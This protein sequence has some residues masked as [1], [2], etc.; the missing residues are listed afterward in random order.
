M[1][2]KYR[3]SDLSDNCIFQR[4]GKIMATPKGM[5]CIKIPLNAGG[6]IHIYSNPENIV[7]QVRNNVPSQENLLTPS[8]KVA[9]EISVS[10]ALSIAGELLSAAAAQVKKKENEII[11]VTEPEQ[12]KE[13]HNGKSVH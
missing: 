6:N 12:R 10:E 1:F 5:R 3:L 7:L 8:F 4:E 13:N 9:A 11:P 2:D